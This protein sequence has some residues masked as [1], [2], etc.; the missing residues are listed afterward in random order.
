MRKPPLK[1]AALLAACLLPQQVIEADP[2]KGP[3]ET[4]RFF[5]P[6]PPGSTYEVLFGPG[7]PPHHLSPRNRYAYDFDMPPGSKVSA[8]ASGT[9]VGVVSRNSGPTGSSRQNNFVAL[10]HPG[11]VISEYHHLM[12]DGALVRVGE[13]VERGEVIGFS[14]QSGRADGPHLH[15]VVVEDER[16]VPIRFAGGERKPQKG[17]RATSRNVPPRLGRKYRLLRRAVPW[18]RILEGEGCP[19]P[20]ALLLD[21]VLAGRQEG[22]R[23][24]VRR[25]AMAI[26]SL[27]EKAEERLHALE[28][29]W[30]E[31]H[32]PPS[33]TERPPIP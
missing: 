30:R 10:R 14:G 25:S 21:R 16:S 8:A 31:R 6:F 20:A 18:A 23:Y 17:E 15:F 22:D 1:S 24:G 26:A 13:R 33:R 9:V 29:E 12:Q 2:G 3:E 19:L 32:E 5:L 27:E 7:D 28:R 11:G 4:T